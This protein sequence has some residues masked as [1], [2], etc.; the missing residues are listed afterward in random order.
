LVDVRL[1]G[2]HLGTATQL[3][4]RKGVVFLDPDDREIQVVSVP[5]VPY[6]PQF[7]VYYDGSLLSNSVGDPRTARR[8]V[9]EL[10][11]LVGVYDISALPILNGQW[12]STWFEW[13]H[14]GC[15]ALAA[16]IAVQVGI[17]WPAAG[18]NARNYML[19]RVILGALQ[20]GG[21]SARFTLD[22]GALALY[23]WMKQATRT[24]EWIDSGAWRGSLP[25]G[26]NDLT[27]PDSSRAN[28]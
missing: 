10:L 11:L 13:T 3:A 25:P 19:F 15:A 28:G 2:E 14:A 24:L 1:D 20:S 26:K 5:G 18:R 9:L 16:V 27:I 12:P 4:L 23:F 7:D 21:N 8:T 22:I 17:R 6:F